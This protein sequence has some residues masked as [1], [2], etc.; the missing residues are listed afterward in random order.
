MIATCYEMI[1]SP[2]PVGTLLHAGG[3][4]RLLEIRGPERHTGMFEFRILS[5]I[6]SA[7]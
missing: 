6:R 2:T 7:V 5:A 1:A 3:I 4:E